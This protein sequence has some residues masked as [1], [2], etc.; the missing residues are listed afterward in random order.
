[1]TRLALRD[2]SGGAAIQSLPERGEHC[3]FRA[4]VS[5]RRRARMGAIP[6]PRNGNDNLQ[7]PSIEPDAAALLF[8]KRTMVFKS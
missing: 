6:R 2:I 8:A 1:M 7:R 5:G 4:I 3:L